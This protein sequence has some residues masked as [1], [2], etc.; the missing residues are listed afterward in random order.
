MSAGGILNVEA[1]DEVAPTEEGVVAPEVLATGDANDDQESAPA[2]LPTKGSDNVRE[3]SPAP[4]VSLEDAP[5]TKVDL[6]SES[7]ND[8]ASPD[9]PGRTKEPQ[10]RL[11]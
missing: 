1:Y 9:A 6:A 7:E 10:V 8:P 2:Q 3:A 5:G 4:S 11:G